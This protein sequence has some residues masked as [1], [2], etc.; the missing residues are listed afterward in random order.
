LTIMCFLILFET[1]NPF[2][3]WRMVPGISNFVFV[4]RRVSKASN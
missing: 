2:V 4:K 1:T 3:F